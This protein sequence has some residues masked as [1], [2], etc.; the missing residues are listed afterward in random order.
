MAKKIDWT[1]DLQGAVALILDSGL[2]CHPHCN[3]IRNQHP[4]QHTSIS[5][6][7]L[8]A[9]QK[10]FGLPPVFLPVC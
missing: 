4:H 9:C 5:R 2:I 10:S 7:L 1:R 3:D 8:P 6:T